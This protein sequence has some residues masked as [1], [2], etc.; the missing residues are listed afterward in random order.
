[1]NTNLVIT[2]DAL[3][4]VKKYTDLKIGIEF[5]KV[6]SKGDDQKDWEQARSYAVEF[7]SSILYNNQD[8]FDF[9]KRYNAERR[10]ADPYYDGI[11]KAKEET[12]NR[13]MEG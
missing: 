4:A 13:L 1:M 12:A 9:W 10:K 5:H 7:L 2:D 8:V 11:M 3:L 6:S